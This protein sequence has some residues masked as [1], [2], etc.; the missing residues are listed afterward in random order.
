MQSVTLWS[1]NHFFRK[2][3]GLS[4]LIQLNAQSMKGEFGV[5]MCENVYLKQNRQEQE[6]K[7]EAII[8]N[9]LPE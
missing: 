3:T 5:C 6:T 2:S 4:E 7:N 1:L 9:D 8:W